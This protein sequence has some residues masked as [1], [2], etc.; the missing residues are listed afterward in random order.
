MIQQ[1]EVS[2]NDSIPSLFGICSL[3]TIALLVET[4]EICTKTLYVISTNF[5]GFH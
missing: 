5:N 1:L 4:T 3:F 2:Y